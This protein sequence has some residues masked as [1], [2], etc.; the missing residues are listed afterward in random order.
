[1][2]TTKTYVPASVDISW[3][4]W[5]F[6]GY[7]DGT[8]IEVSRSRPNTETMVG[9]DNTVGITKIGDLTGTVTI[10]LMQNSRTNWFLSAAQA[11]QDA[12]DNIFRADMAVR[13][14]SGSFFVY[15]KA[16]HIQEPATMTLSNGQT[17]KVWTF[18]AEEIRYADTIP[19]AGITAGTAVQIA[20]A[21]SGLKAISDA[22]N[23]TI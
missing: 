18:F 4:G 15:V 3:G 5:G 7:A 6:E 20:S 9:A 1:M 19:E 21:V 11:A 13:D 8:F 10:T 23:A 16:A 2:A 12:S 17:A 22:L 14:K